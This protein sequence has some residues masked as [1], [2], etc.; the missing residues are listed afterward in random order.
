VATTSIE[1]KDG[2]FVVLVG[3][4]GCGKS[5]LLRMIAGLETVSHDE[6]TFRAFGAED[7]ES[8]HGLGSARCWNQPGFKAHL[9]C[10]SAKWILASGA[11]AHGSV[12]NVFL[13]ASI[14][15]G[16]AGDLL[17]QTDP[18][19]TIDRASIF[20]DPDRTRVSG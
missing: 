15:Y 12:L 16:P 13:T 18:L 11:T 7:P 9:L 6:I 8:S 1:I 17:Y 2:E 5:T 14:F 20:S 19:S 3:P 4:S 10:T